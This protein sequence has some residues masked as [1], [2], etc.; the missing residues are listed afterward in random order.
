MKKTC[1]INFTRKINCVS[2]KNIKYEKKPYFFS[3]LFI[4]LLI[5]IGLKSAIGIPGSDLFKLYQSMINNNIDV[6][7][8]RNEMTASFAPIGATRVCKN[9]DDID[10]CFCMA[11]ASDGPGALNLSNGV[12]QAMTEQIPCIYLINRNI[13]EDNYNRVIQQVNTPLMYKNI[14]KSIIEIDKKYIKQNNVFDKIY[15]ALLLAFSYPAGPIVFFLNGDCFDF[16]ILTVYKIEQINHYVKKFLNIFKNKY[17]YQICKNIIGPN[18]TNGLYC[19][20]W[21]NTLKIFKK[22]NKKKIINKYKNFLEKLIESSKKPVFLF[23]EGSGIFTFNEFFINICHKLHIP[24]L[25]TTPMKQIVDN[26]DVFYA[27]STG[28]YGTYCGNMTI[29]NADLLICFGTSFNLYM[30]IDLLEPFKN[31]KNIVSVNINPELY[32]TPF[33]DFY[34]IEDAKKVIGELDI[35]NINIDTDERNKWI[36]K[37]QEY[38][39]IG[40]NKLDYFFSKN[41][42]EILKQ[43][44][45]YNVLQYHIDKFNIIN[46]KKYIYFV[47][48]AGSSQLYSTSLLNFRNKYQLISSLKWGSIGDGLGLLI[49]AALKNPDDLFILISG[50]G[51][52]MLSLGDYITIKES[53]LK[54]IIIIIIENGGLALVSEA[55]LE[56]SS[57][58]LEY[59]NGYKTYPNWINLF[60]GLNLNTS[61]AK[62]KY[63]FNC[64]LNKAINNEL[65]KEPVVIVAVVSM[66]LY[67]APITP[68][69]TSADNMKY[70]HDNIN[71]KIDICRINKL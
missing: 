71:W 48:D 58:T 10:R 47:V 37:I 4:K 32:K 16:D 55:S 39:K 18:Y 33:V 64:I 40:L 20:N 17:G 1:K 12:A 66:D 13:N 46:S 50:D 67:Y 26:D 31:I 30:T 60:N 36:T 25:L 42:N 62:T 68:I 51:G 27:Q 70:L 19:L 69:G 41:D 65:F 35:K 57:K 6:I 38:K 54:N 15:N 61:I 9:R 24:Y 3:E 44:D 2:K 28:H 22:K 45:I 56:V 11:F 34:I 52:T 63:E 59:G 8:S 21:E 43:G 7:L 5:S 53:N 49:G 14:S 23:G 29:T